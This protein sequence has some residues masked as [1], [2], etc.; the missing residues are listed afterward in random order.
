[1]ALVH[2]KLC[3]LDHHEAVDIG[4]YVRE[5]CDTLGKVHGARERGIRITLEVEAL[6]IGMESSMPLGLLLNE[7]VCNSLKHGYPPQARPQGGTVR[8]R[9]GRAAD[10]RGLLEVE[11][12]GIGFVPGVD[13]GHPQSLGLRLAGSLARQLGG[14]LQMPAPDAPGSAAGARTILRFDLNRAGGADRLAALAR[15]APAETLPA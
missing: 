11:D 3:Q 5:L 15:P 10:G 13:M 8:V 14:S 7:L 9:L 2:E 12:D 1:M 6:A 4:A